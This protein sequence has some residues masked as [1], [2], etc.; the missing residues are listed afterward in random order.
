MITIK[1]TENINTL[2][3]DKREAKIRRYF[4]EKNAKWYYS[5]VDVIGILTDST[6]ARNY[7]KVLKNRLKKSSPEL[8]TKCN[9]LKM[10]AKDGKYYL[11][12]TADAET[13]MQIIESVPRATVE[14]FKALIRDIEEGKIGEHHSPNQIHLGSE[15]TLDEGEIVKPEAI[16][17]VVEE[18]SA[19][20]ELLVDAYQTATEIFVTAMIAGLELEDINISVSDK[21]ITIAGERKNLLKDCEPLCEELSWTTFSRTLSLHASVDVNKI[22]KNIKHGKLTIKLFKV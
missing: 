22:E 5:V 3:G 18:N 7:W 1:I 2:G 8:V 13:M 10:K 14:A 19:E 21:K 16:L 20:L 6:D 17:E 15:K 4:D 12:D 9:Q 11:T